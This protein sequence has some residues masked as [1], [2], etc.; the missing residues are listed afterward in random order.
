LLLLPIQSVSAA[1]G[2]WLAG[3]EPEVL[4][5]RAASEADIQMLRQRLAL[6][7]AAMR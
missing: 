3:A 5:M 7:S 6:P 2:V 1:G 4:N